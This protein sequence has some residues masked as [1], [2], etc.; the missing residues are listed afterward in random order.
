MCVFR[1]NHS[2]DRGECD[3]SPLSINP[4]FL[5]PSTLDLTSTPTPPRG[6]FLFCLAVSSASPLPFT[7]IRPSLSFFFTLPPDLNTRLSDVDALSPLFSIT[8]FIAPPPFF[9][10]G[11]LMS[12]CGRWRDEETKEVKERRAEKGS[13]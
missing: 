4:P 8:L 2:S 9:F 12:G 11:A 7:P 1:H 5:S 13:Y 6:F 3:L 10:F